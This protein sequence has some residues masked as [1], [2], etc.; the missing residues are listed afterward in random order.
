MHPRTAA[1]VGLLLVGVSA[2][3]LL[4][5]GSIGAPG[6]II[7][8]VG[9]VVGGALLLLTALAWRWDRRRGR[10]YV[11]TSVATDG[12]IPVEL[13]VG[14]DDRSREAGTAFAPG[15]AAHEA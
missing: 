10:G 12:S 5:A 8:S 15:A 14:D 13:E 3:L 1:L 4:R 6:A 9:L 11:R 2:L 7:G